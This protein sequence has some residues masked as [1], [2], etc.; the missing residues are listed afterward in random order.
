ML[1]VAGA[2]FSYWLKFR[3]VHK[4]YG[5]RAPEIR[6]AE[7]SLQPERKTFRAWL[8]VPPFVWLAGVAWYVQLNWSRIPERFPIHWG[9]NGQPNGWASRS[10]NGVY[11]PLLLAVFMDVFFLLFAIALLR[12]SR[13][14]TMRQVTVTMLLLLMYPVSFAFGMVALL[15]LVTFPMWL[16]PVVTLGTVA[17]LIAWSIR[18]ITAPAAIDAVPEPQNDAYWKAG[19]FYYNPDDPAI[20]VSKRVGIG[21]T[22]NF[23]NKTAWL[24]LVGILLM[25]LLPALL[26]RAK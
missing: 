8:C 26:L 1:L 11:G 4:L 10:F 14:T 21:Y 20:F 5:R 12:I 9:T 7:L 17:V 15:P 22:M 24:V 25:A 19:V 6:V 2:A 16:V 23:A 13:N 3:E 18:R